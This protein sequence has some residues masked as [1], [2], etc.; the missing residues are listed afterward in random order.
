MMEN[1]FE[2][3]QQQLRQVFCDQAT[4]LACGHIL[5]HE[6]GSQLQRH[7]IAWENERRKIGITIEQEMEK[8]FLVSPGKA[9][10]TTIRHQQ[11]LDSF[12]RDIDDRR[13]AVTRK[14][15][16]T[17]LTWLQAAGGSQESI[18]NNNNTNLLLQQSQLLPID[19]GRHSEQEEEEQQ[20][21]K[22]I[23]FQIFG[24]GSQERVSMKISLSPLETLEKFLPLIHETDHVDSK[25]CA[26]RAIGMLSRFSRQ[27]D[28][29]S[30]LIFCGNNH[31]NNNNSD[32]LMKEFS[33]TCLDPIRDFIFD[34]I[35]EE[36]ERKKETH[37]D[38]DG[39]SNQTTLVVRSKIL[40]SSSQQVKIFPIRGIWA[41][42]LGV[43]ID[44]NCTSSIVQE[45]VD[46]CASMWNATMI[47]V[48][49]GNSLSTAECTNVAS[50]ICEAIKTT[51]QD[52]YTSLRVT[53]RNGIKIPCSGAQQIS[54]SI[55]SPLGCTV[56]FF[57]PKFKMQNVENSLKKK[58]A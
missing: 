11:L 48:V 1:N 12:L 41:A 56:R 8:S 29:N 18:S 19:F 50:M 27:N 6:V 35:L 16:K 39:K 20:Q 25:E 26:M 31:N 44:Q 28:S 5:S 2:L 45:I 40:S 30:I 36:E 58:V 42:N 14:S 9:H 23:Q 34:I 13:A 47:T 10:E 57:V 17:F 43:L 7:K 53:S 46:H 37:Q 3:V 51:C 21:H 52:C 22:E 55:S 49:L 54:K 4:T 33:K 32:I 38:D 24:S 15:R